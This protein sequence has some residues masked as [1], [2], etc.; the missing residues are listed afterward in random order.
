MPCSL[1]IFNL[2]A[3]LKDQDLLNQIQADPDLG[4]SYLGRSAQPLY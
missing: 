2:V 1:L 4:A 3:V